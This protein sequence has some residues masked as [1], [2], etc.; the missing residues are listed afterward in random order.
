MPGLAGRRR[1][2]SGA[3][4][5]GEPRRWPPGAPRHRPGQAEVDQHRPA[6]AQHHVAR[7]DVQVGQAA[8]VEVAEGGGQ[9][10]ADQQHVDR[11]E[12]P[13]VGQGVVEGRPLDVLEDECGRG[14]SRRARAA[15]G[16]RVGGRAAPPPGRARPPPGRPR[17]AG[18]ASPPPGTSG[19]GP[20]PARSRS[21]GRRRAA[22][23]PA[24]RGQLVAGRPVPGRLGVHG[25]SFVRGEGEGPP[26]APSPSGSAARAGTGPRARP[27]P[28]HRRGAVAAVVREHLVAASDATTASTSSA[29]ELTPSP[30]LPV[31]ASSCGCWRAQRRA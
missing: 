1:T 21:A 20:R 31:S 16:S 4:H 18:A 11:V 13:V 8:A 29:H 12:G 10:H 9:L 3:I 19:R 2:C 27:R 6:V 26:S 17:R 15:G 23:R 24:A 22:P 28:G 30:D 25:G 14:W 5:G 7:L